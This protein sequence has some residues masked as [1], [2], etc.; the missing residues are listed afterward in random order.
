MGCCSLCS[1]LS[2]SSPGQGIFLN[3]S[4]YL[5]LTAYYNADWASRPIS[6]RSL[7]RYFIFLGDFPI[8]WKTKKEP[9]VSRWSAETEYRSMA[10]I[11][12]ELKWI[13]RLLR[14]LHVH[15]PYPVLL[16]CGSQAAMHITIN[17]VFHEKTKHIEINWLSLR[18]WWV[19]GILHHSYVCTFSISTCRY[20]HQSFGPCTLLCF[21]TK[22]HIQNFHTPTWGEYW[23]R[24]SF[25]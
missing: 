18:L 10:M 2:K 15:Y 25:P 9:A 6:R 4:L 21:I 22:L 12:C 13:R 14:D 8:S 23:R 20:F 24:D 17:P 16:Y 19:S 3:A 11:C 5:V 7:I 1:P